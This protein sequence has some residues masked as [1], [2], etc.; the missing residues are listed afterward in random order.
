MM[1]EIER[2]ERHTFSFHDLGSTNAV[3]RSKL[4]M[5]FKKLPIMELGG[6]VLLAVSKNIVTTILE[7]VYSI[8]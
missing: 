5:L 2:D 4:N 7:E 1:A 3:D 8:F 6:K